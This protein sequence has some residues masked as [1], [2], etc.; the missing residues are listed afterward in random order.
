MARPRTVTDEQI[1]EAARAV[2]THAGAGSSVASIGARLGVTHSA[3]LQ[4]FGSKR[5][6]FLRAMGP[7]GPPQRVLEAL[8]SGPREGAS[9][10]DQLSPMLLD[11][12]VFLREALPVLLA[13]RAA[14]ADLQREA[15]EGMPVLLRAALAGW[16]AAADGAGWARVAHAAATSE[17][18]LGALEARVLNDHLGSISPVPAEDAAWVRELVLGLVPV[19]RPKEVS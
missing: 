3:I 19:P 1:L 14:G 6:L 4:R 15:R 12:L 11:L 18:L 5:T 9:I 17:G 2:F 7:A 13:F 10:P 8:G 16:L